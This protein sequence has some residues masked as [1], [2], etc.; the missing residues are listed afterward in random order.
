M[1]LR[2]DSWFCTWGSVLVV[3]LNPLILSLS[4]KGFVNAAWTTSHIRSSAVGVLFRDFCLSGLE[5]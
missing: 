1:I 5:W 2:G 4:L 3:H